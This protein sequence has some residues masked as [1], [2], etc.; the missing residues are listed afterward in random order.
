MG[1]PA[2]FPPEVSQG[3]SEPD[4]RSDAYSFAVFAYEVLTGQRPFDA[5]DALSLVTA[6][7]TRDPMP[8]A[9]AL[10]GFPDAAWHILLRGMDR[11]PA[12]RPL[13]VSLMSQ[14]TALPADQWPEVQRRSREDALSRRSDPTVH[15]PGFRPRNA[16]ETRVNT[17]PPR[18]RLR[19]RRSPH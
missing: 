10:A 1:T 16:T 5:P 7:W 13:P 2:Y 19:G 3:I 6:H 18:G 14:L 11:E 12:A 4:A 8:A 9:Q 15:Q 17:V